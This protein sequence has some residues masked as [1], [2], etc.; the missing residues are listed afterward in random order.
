MKIKSKTYLMLLMLAS[1]ISCSQEID[2]SNETV[3]EL[4]PIRIHFVVNKTEYD[5]QDATR[6]GGSGTG[7]EDGEV[8]Y[9]YFDSKVYGQAVY[10]IKTREWTVKYD[11][12]L[13]ITNNGW[14]C[15]HYFD[16]PT[17]ASSSIVTLSPFTGIY[18]TWSGTY[19][20]TSD[21]VLSIVLNLVP[22]TSR[23]RF[24]GTIGSTMTIYE[25]IQTL[26]S[27]DNFAFSASVDSIPVHLTVNNDGYTPYVYCFSDNSGKLEISNGKYYYTTDLPANTLKSGESGWMNIPTE[28]EHNGW[29][30][31]NFEDTLGLCP[32]LK[33]PHQIDMGTGVKFACCN[34]GA[35]SPIEYGGYYAWGEKETKSVYNWGT[36]KWRYGEKGLLI[37]YNMHSEFG[38]VDNKNQLELSDDAASANWNRT[39]RMP[40]EDEWLELMTEC[41]WEY[42][43]IGGICGIK[44][45][46]K[47][48]NT[49]FLPAGDFMMENRIYSPGDWG[50]YWSSSLSTTNSLDA[51][52]FLFYYKNPFTSINSRDHGYNVRAVT[53]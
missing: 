18:N 34:V 32:N 46:S 3:K 24:H 41:A 50:R 29:D 2:K 35:T 25:G 51:K 11:G 45:T 27:F 33:H 52:C 43:T 23:I 36:Y 17:D 30:I 48:H 39:W 12:D 8:I 26:S 42:T 16:K 40:T 1:Q 9:L 22:F 47:S 14:L 44:F 10:D 20:L 7:W 31:S 5:S 38:A 13:F 19:S 21:G 28:S 4:Q 15:A 6:S 37:K 53:E 49:I